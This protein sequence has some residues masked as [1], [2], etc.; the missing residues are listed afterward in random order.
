M[1]L[2]GQQ[3]DLDTFA[4]DFFKEEEEVMPDFDQ[5][6]KDYLG[7][8][9]RGIVAA[10]TDGHVNLQMRASGGD[11][12]TPTRTLKDILATLD[13]LDKAEI[14]GLTDAQLRLIAKAVADE[15]ARRMAS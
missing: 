6:Q 15:Q 7:N 11:T 12:W 9:G 1:N 4:Q 14:A 8:L 3:V 2:D 13:E 10:L 5:V